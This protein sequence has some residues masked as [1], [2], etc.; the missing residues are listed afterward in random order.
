MIDLKKLGFQKGLL[1]WVKEKKNNTFPNYRKFPWR[2]YKNRY[3]ILITEIL[4]Q[5]TNS[6]QV[7]EIWD[8]FFEKFP[9]FN[10]ILKAGINDLKNI[11]IPLGLQNEKSHRILEIAKKVLS[12]HN[13]YVPS[14]KK[15]LTEFKGVGNYIAHAVLCFGFG[16]KFE[17]IDTNVI[18][19]YQRIFD[20]K[21]T[22]KRPRSDKKI[23]EFAHTLLPNKNF[24]LFN[25]ALLDFGA[26]ICISR[27]PKCDCC[28]FNNHC[29][30]FLNSK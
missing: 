19:I 18:R 15:L 13:G 30:Y 27:N 6:N 12:E 26:K 11:L 10:E 14:D 4:L 1:K 9:S 28:F 3:I 23:W 16:K 25:F 7:S 21:S 29:L 5:K 20:L 24:R 22:K 17:I 8:N 2:I